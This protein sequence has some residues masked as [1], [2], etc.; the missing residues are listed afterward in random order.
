[1]VI[2]APSG[3]GKTTIY[4]EFLKKRP[5]ISFSVSYTTR[6]RRVGETDG[7]DYFFIS[8][9]EFE[10]KIERGDFIEWAEVHKDL[11]GTDWKYLEECLS[12]SSA[13]IL[14]V[15]VQGALNIM[16][17]FPEALTIYIRPPSIEELR[18]RLEKRGTESKSS[19][20]IR[21]HNAEK[22]LEY[23]DRFQYIV[24]NDR[25]EKAVK[26]IEEIIDGELEKRR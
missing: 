17:A 10:Q 22:E 11:K 15:D 26:R 6:Q 24:M 8:R 3:S 23:Q 18:K 21:L 16:K 7:V 9:E 25:V 1:V 2:T 5:D 20:R 12:R 4:R 14:D 19:V 13:C